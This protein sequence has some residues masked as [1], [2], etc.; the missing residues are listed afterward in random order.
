[1][2]PQTGDAPS[3]IPQIQSQKRQHEGKHMGTVKMFRTAYGFIRL[4][5]SDD[6]VYVNIE[7]LKDTDWLKE[8]Q[9]VRFRIETLEENGQKSSRAREVE[10]IKQTPLERLRGASHQS[11]PAQE[12]AVQTSMPTSLRVVTYN[13]LAPCCCEDLPVNNC[14]AEDIDE[15]VR[16]ERILKKIDNAI[17]D[18][19]P[20]V[21]CLQEVEELWAFKLHVYFQ[22]RSWHFV[23]SDD[24]GVA[25]AFPNDAMQLQEMR[26]ITLADYLQNELPPDSCPDLHDPWYLAGKRQNRFLALLLRHRSSTRCFAIVTYHMPCLV[27]FDPDDP[28]SG[29]ARC[30]ARTVHTA[31]L[32]NAADEFANGCSLI[33]AG[34]F[35]TKPGDSQL[36]LVKDFHL[37][38][39]DVNYPP[40]K[41]ALKLSSWLPSGSEQVRRLRSA[42]EDFLGH[43]PAFTNFVVEKDPKDPFRET[44]DYI[45]VS[46]EIEVFGVG[47]TPAVPEE[48]QPSYLT[49]YPSQEEPSDHVLIYADLRIGKQAVLTNHSLQ[50]C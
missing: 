47:S 21:V 12:H 7:D 33:L 14:R 36:R 35:N 20:T 16:W 32:R 17:A 6:S 29:L 38:A 49:G 4:R 13:L 50:S 15:P 18:D 30:R 31:L 28:E 27:D 46:E 40:D 44:I 37:D 41:G 8:G 25:M 9:T 23:W 2:T 19:K 43:E 3:Q 48:G 5:R 22:Q 42:Y 24:C 1:M 39:Q 45:F 34:D 11:M 10:V 26:I